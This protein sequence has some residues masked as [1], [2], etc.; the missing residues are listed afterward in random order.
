MAKQ[1]YTVSVTDARRKSYPNA[2][3]VIEEKGN[4]LSN[5]FLGALECIILQ[6]DLVGKNAKYTEW[7]IEGISLKEEGGDK[8]G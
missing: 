3:R 1:N 7:A 4:N 8:D 2:C 5:M 6:N